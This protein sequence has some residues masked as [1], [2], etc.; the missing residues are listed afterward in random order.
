MAQPGSL[1]VVHML[2]PQAVGSYFDR[3]RWPLHIT[4]LPWF[5]ATQERHHQLEQELTRVAQST[6]PISV[7]VGEQHMFGPGKNVPVNIIADREKL[8]S[9][10][11]SL[12]SLTRLLQLP[13]DNAAFTGRQYTA[14]IS[15]Y[16]DRF[17]NQGD[18]LR[19]ADFYLVQLLDGRTC[20]IISRF[21]LRGRNG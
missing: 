6:P 4:L 12:L 3:Q 16:E 14:H 2:E 21:E 19:V 18:T 11:E 8:Q 20:Q 10:H 1:I 7:A 9:L 13:L 15:R 5:H 17:V